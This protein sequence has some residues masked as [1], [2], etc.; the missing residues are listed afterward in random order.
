M[1]LVRWDPFR[2]LEEFSSRLNRFFA[3]EAR[4]W[5]LP[6][7][8]A[9]KE[10]MTFAEWAPAV[11]IKETPEEY[12]IKAELPGIDKNDVKVTLKEGVLTLSGERKLEKEEKGE[13]YHRVERGYGKFVRSFTL[14]AEID[15]KKLLADYKGG[16]LFVHLPKS[17]AAMPKAIEVKVT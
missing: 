3:K 2:E 13:K 12:L 7:A 1:N 15:D 5:Y 6:S 11:D 17:P 8:E 14:P 9:S 10:L 4:P 16:V